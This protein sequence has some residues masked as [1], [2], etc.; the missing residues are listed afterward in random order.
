V[1][2]HDGGFAAGD[3][4]GDGDTNP[5]HPRSPLS[6]GGDGDAGD[7]DAGDGNAGD[8]DAGDGDI[9]SARA[10]VAVEALGAADL[11]G[12]IV[13]SKC[14]LGVMK[15]GA[16]LTHKACAELCLRGGIPPILVTTGAAGEQTG[17][18]LAR[19]DGG[20]AAVELAE[21]AADPVRVAGQLQR[22]GG[23]L[24]LRVDAVQRR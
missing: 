3:G 13:D 11:S 1:A 22:Q 9:D 10:A 14:F 8:G 20:S 18:L 5:G 12:E 15:P 16:G 17:Y 23:L 21:F 19:A 24:V 6:G 2:L 7:G 4:I